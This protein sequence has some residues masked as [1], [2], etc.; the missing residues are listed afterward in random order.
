MKTVQIGKHSVVMFD[1]IEDLPISRYHKYNKMLLIDSGLGSDLTDVDAHIEKT[2][3]F[4]KIDDKDSAIK[5]MLNMRKAIYFV[6]MALSPKHLAF[7]ALVKSVDGKECDDLSD[8]GL[9]KVVD[10]L[11]DSASKDLVEAFSEAKKKIDSELIAYFPGMFDNPDVKEYYNLLKERTMETLKQME[12]GNDGKR[13]EDITNELLTFEKPVEFDGAD[14]AEI[15]VDKNYERMCLQ[16]AQHL[17][18]DAKKYTT[19]A[20]YNAF[21]YLRESLKKQQKQK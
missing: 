4:I 8:D 7:A 15:A 1:S 18:I 14:S 12:D 2:V 6:Q 10:L 21:E 19:L 3:A 11:C 16:M 9:K 20:F 17:N 13:I 5:E